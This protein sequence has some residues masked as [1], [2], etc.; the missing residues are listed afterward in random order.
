[1][2]A[3]IHDATNESPDFLWYGIRR[4]IHDFRVWGC[5]IEAMKGNTLTNLEDR[6]ESGYFLGTTATRSVIRYWNPKHPDKIGYCT[7]ARFDEY[8]TYDPSGEL[9]PGSRLTQGKFDPDTTINLTTVSEINHPLLQ[10]PIEKLRVKLPPKGKSIGITISKCDF[11]NLPYISKS[12]PS[13][14]YYQSVKKNLRH[15]VWI[16]AIA[17]NAPITPH[18]ALQ[19]LQDQQVEGK[20]THIDMVV[21]KRDTTDGKRTTLEDRWAAFNQIRMV[22][23]KM[24]DSDAINPEVLKNKNRH[25]MDNIK[26]VNATVNGETHKVY[27]KEPPD[28]PNLVPSSNHPNNSGY[29]IVKVTVGNDTTTIQSPPQL[30]TETKSIVKKI[31]TR[32]SHYLKLLQKLE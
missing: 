27:Q 11:H 14:Y 28:D 2:G 1:M 19:D 24:I 31:W 26:A 4:S 29:K 13:S 12:H 15:N 21:S 10:H 5:H 18:Q 6:T 25:N 32:I 3:T 8:Q 7:T 16:L 22:R 23:M 17:N 20:P 9:S 30:E